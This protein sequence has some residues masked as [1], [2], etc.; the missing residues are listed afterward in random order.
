[1]M[2]YKNEGYITAVQFFNNFTEDEIKI[3]LYRLAKF[4]DGKTWK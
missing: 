2:Y 3:K 1:M 4:Y